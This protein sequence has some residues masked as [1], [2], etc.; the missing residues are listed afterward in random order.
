[1][2]DKMKNLS[3]KDIMKMDRFDRVNLISSVSGIKAAMLIG[4]ISKHNIS[5]VA[6]FSSIIH[7]GSNPALIGLLIR[8]QTKRVSDTYQNIKSNK[9]FT[10]NHVNKNIISKAHYTS[11]KTSSN[12]SEFDDVGL[13]E[14]YIGNLQS[15]FVKEA[16]VGLGLIYCDEISLSNKCIL[17]IGEIDN[18]KLRNDLADVNG[19]I[20]LSNYNSIGVDGIGHYYKLN[21][22]KNYE[23]VGTRKVPKEKLV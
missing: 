22:T 4:T 5:N 19:L 12:T 8:P 21:L 3:K 10:I 7:L 11:A 2:K 14:E 1:M 9:S 16:D 15:P 23:Y 17:V 18:I 13:T 6:I 20:N